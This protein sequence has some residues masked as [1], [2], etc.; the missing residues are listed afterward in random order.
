MVSLYYSD[1]N[2]NPRSLNESFWAG[3]FASE[4]I[5]LWEP[6]ERAFYT[7]NAETGIYEEESVDAIKRRLSDRLLEASRQTN[8]PWL[9][10]QRSDSRLNSIV[11]HLRGIV[12]RRDAF[13][14]RERRIHLANGVFSFEKD[15]ELLPFSPAF[16]S[17]NRSP[18]VFDENAKCERFLNELICP[19]VHEDDAVLMQKYA[20]LSLLGVN[21]IQRMLIL[22]GNQHE[23]K[24]SLQT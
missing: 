16:V 22:D 7:Y 19:A 8:C 17:R 13:A 6:S 5:I 24:R 12:E 18:I 10:K 15:G 4:N 11:A 14:E 20:G 3:L 23:A 9:E 21:L 2:G 1:E